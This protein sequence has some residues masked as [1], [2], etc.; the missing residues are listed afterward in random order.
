MSSINSQE[1]SISA[2]SIY[3]KDS[4]GYDPRDPT[5]AK[6]HES[7]LERAAAQSHHS[8]RTKVNKKNK[9]MLRALGAFKQGEEE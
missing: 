7:D 8:Q 2:G 1:L 5:T 3:G 6:D 9:Y 4:E